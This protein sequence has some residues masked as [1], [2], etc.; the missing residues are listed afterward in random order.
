MKVT[1]PRSSF[2]HQAPVEFPVSTSNMAYADRLKPRCNLNNRRILNSVSSDTSEESGPAVTRPSS[3]PAPGLSVQ[4]SP[5]QRRARDIV[6]KYRKNM[7]MQEFRRLKSIVPSV[8]DDEKASQ[9]SDCKNWYES[10]VVCLARLKCTL[11]IWRGF[12]THF[13]PNRTLDEVD[14]SRL[15]ID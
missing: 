10:V 15:S 11:S 4:I 2:F 5:S 12:M 9:V 8:A 7:R 13:C 3:R 6:R 14:W 1:V